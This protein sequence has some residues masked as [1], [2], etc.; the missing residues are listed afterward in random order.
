MRRFVRTDDLT[1]ISLPNNYY[2]VAFS[3]AR[4]RYRLGWEDASASEALLGK[5][6]DHTASPTRR[7]GRGVSTATPCC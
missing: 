2:G 6:L 4:L 5:T 7:T 1:L 3:V